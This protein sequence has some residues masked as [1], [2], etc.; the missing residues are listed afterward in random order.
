[1]TLVIDYGM[2]MHADALP[3]E[4]LVMIAKVRDQNYVPHE[5]ED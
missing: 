5:H 4:N 3:T 1:V 2:G